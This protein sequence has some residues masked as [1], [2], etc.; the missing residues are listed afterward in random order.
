LVITATSF[1]HVW[2]INLLLAVL[3]VVAAHVFGPRRGAIV[4]VV[5]TLA[6]AALAFVGPAVTATGVFAVLCETGQVGHP[7][8]SAFW[9]GSLLSVVLVLR[10]IRDPRFTAD[11][12]LALRR[13]SGLGH[14]AVALALGSGLANSWIVLRDKP[15]SL[16]TAYQ[17]LLLVKVALVG[18]M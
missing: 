18:S 9:V 11:A 5:A 10:Q 7:I 2:V 14:A 6:L 3:A 12:D 1:G 8:S 17:V 13:F 16:G 15:L 4:A